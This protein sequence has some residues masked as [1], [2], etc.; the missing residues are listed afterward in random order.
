[1]TAT[2]GPQPARFFM[3][4]CQVGAENALKGEMARGPLAMVPAFVRPGFVTFKLVE[5]PVKLDTL[6]VVQ[7]CF[8]RTLV[9]SI[10]RVEHAEMQTAADQLWQLPSVQ[11]L[12]S[13]VEN[14]DL[15]VWQRDLAEPGE[16]AFRPAVTLLA[17]EV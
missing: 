12:S 11:E 8:A 3:A 10:G 15:H 1:M 13:A 17:E 16:H 2:S 9:V 14:V 4:T 6:S 7:P 5:S